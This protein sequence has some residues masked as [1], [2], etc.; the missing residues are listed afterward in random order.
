MSTGATNISCRLK[1]IFAS[2]STATNDAILRLTFLSCGSK[3]K[4]PMPN[5]VMLY[6]TKIK[7][8]Y[9]KIFLLYLDQCKTFN[10]FH[11]A[12]T[13]TATKKTLCF[14]LVQGFN[15]NKHFYVKLMMFSSLQAFNTHQWRIF[16]HSE[17]RRRWGP[18]QGLRGTHI[19]KKPAAL[20]L[21]N[22]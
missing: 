4:P 16:Q 7:K 15:R 21:L 14:P 20:L 22:S 8:K 17:E 6:C 11:W 10:P 2:P 5:N 3:I 12:P 19:W 13:C 9:I 18:R 1:I